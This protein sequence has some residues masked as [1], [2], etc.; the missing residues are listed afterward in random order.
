MGNMQMPPPEN[1]IRMMCG[2]GQFGSLK[3]VCI[4]TTVKIRGGV[5]RQFY[6]PWLVGTSRRY[7]VAEWTSELLPTISASGPSAEKANM[8]VTRHGKM[9]H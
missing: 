4:T 7:R 8:A 5:A 2:D 1:T 3:I 9:Q 6:R